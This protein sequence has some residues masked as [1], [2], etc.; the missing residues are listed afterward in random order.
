MTVA[1]GRPVL[2]SPAAL[3][4]LP[5]LLARDARDSHSN[6]PPAMLPRPKTL[7]LPYIIATVLLPLAAGYYLSYVFRT[8]NAVIAS[9]LATEFELGPAEL[10]FMT[11]VYFLAF[12]AVQL[13]AGV[14]LD[15]YGPRRVQSVLLLV[16][17]VGS[18][19]FASAD[20]VPALMLGRVL[21]G[22]GVA[23]ALMAGLKAIVLWVPGDRVALANGGMV[24]LGALGA[25]T[26]T[27]PAEMLIEQL[28][29]RGLFLLLTWL[30]VVSAL[31]IYF[32][33]PE[34]KVRRPSGGAAS[35]GLRAIYT[36][37]RFWRIAP[38]SAMTTA[39]SWSIQGLWAAPWLAQVEELERGQVVA[40]LFA[41]AIAL[42]VG[43]LLLGVVADRFRRRGISPQN[44]L[45]AVGANAILAQLVIILR[46]PVLSYG[47]WIIVSV[48]GVA[49]VLSFA[50]MAELFAKEASGRANA[51]LN[52]LHVGSA[53][54]IQCL[55]GF[56]VALWPEQS[57]HHPAI[58]YQSAFAVNLA[59]QVS[60]LA[61][62]LLRHRASKAPVF[63]AHAIHH[64]PAVRTHSLAAGAGYERAIEIWIT[65]I[66]AARHQV[67][68]WRAAALA[69][70]VLMFA[71]SGSFA[72]AVATG[73]MVAVHVVGRDCVV[74]RDVITTNSRSASADLQSEP[75][76][77]ARESGAAKS[78][79]PSH[80]ER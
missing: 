68:T 4:A 24:M 19:L 39:T 5:R 13:P 76:L 69:S 11:S 59:L 23:A 15:R 26:A 9:S 34:A 31:V 6:R 8:I 37:P 79:E 18:L 30:C 77:A 7:P 60:A 43:A 78:L 52:L 28:G 55:T 73:G 63:L 32:V 54:L 64:R 56:V 44:L 48:A 80:A 33:V 67:A 16:A 70:A 2:A 42:S 1:L 72:Q 29:W 45:A 49:T 50:S 47:A 22:F 35:L 58:A 14:A 20:T 38:M 74:C 17:A 12:V 41:M 75:G 66:A 62:F 57:G 65:C 3:R 40:H 36:D 71:L 46:M 27:A 10:G 21:I 61:W 25:V 51:A 53:F